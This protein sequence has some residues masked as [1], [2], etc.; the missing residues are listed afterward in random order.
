MKRCLLLLACFAGLSAFGGVG[1]SVVPQMP[2]GKC[3]DVWVTLSDV[4]ADQAIGFRVGGLP[5]GLHL[6]YWIR[7]FRVLKAR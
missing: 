7:N 6:K 2:W 5:K 4:N 3:V 1:V